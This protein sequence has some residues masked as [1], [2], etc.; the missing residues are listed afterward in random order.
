MNMSVIWSWNCYLFSFQLSVGS[1]LQQQQ[2]AFFLGDDSSNDALVIVD[3]ANTSS[4]VPT[5]TTGKRGRGRPKGSGTGRGRPR[6]RGGTKRALSAAEIAGAQAGMT[7]AYAAYGYNFTGKYGWFY[8]PP[9]SSI[10]VSKILRRAQS[11]DVSFKTA[12]HGHL[13]YFPAN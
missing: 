12:L 2:P 8:I 3:D 9:S 11:L 7:A 5:P 4:P 13:G 6:G 1:E 10:F